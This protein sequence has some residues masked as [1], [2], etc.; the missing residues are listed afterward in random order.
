MTCVRRY[1]AAGRPP[2]HHRAVATVAREPRAWTEGDVA[3]VLTGMLR[4]MDQASN[5]DATPTGRSH[6]ADSAGS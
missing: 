5:P 4:A 3:S 6:C 1:L 2:R